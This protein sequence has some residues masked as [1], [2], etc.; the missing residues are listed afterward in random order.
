MGVFV[1]V[2]LPHILLPVVFKEWHYLFSHSELG[3][4]TL[5]TQQNAHHVQHAYLFLLSQPSVFY[6]LCSYKRFCKL[7]KTDTGEQRQPSC[8]Q[9]RLCIWEFQGIGCALACVYRMLWPPSFLRGWGISSTV[10][11]FVSSEHDQMIILTC[12]GGFV[13]GSRSQGCNQVSRM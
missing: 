8:P 5:S 12:N 4:L 10:S 3:Y 1:Y 2:C 7:L 9:H 13:T 11:E 6:T